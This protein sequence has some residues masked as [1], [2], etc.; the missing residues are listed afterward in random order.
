[1]WWKADLRDRG[2]V[3]VVHGAVRSSVSQG[4]RPRDESPGPFQ[5]ICGWTVHY[6]GTGSPAHQRDAST[7]LPPVRGNRGF[8]WAV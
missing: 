2:R 4:G 1:M 8:P 7:S 5:T 3:Q 6:N